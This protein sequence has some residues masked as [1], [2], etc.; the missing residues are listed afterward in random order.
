MTVKDIKNM[1]ADFDDNQKVYF[2]ISD[3]TLEELSDSYRYPP[4]ISSAFT[5]SCGDLVVTISSKYI[6]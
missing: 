4:T 3:S 6:R 2:D 1:F 5:D